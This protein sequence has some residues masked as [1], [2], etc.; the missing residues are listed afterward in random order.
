[1]KKNFLLYLGLLLG[2]PSLFAM[3]LPPKPAK[4]LPEDELIALINQNMSPISSPMKVEKG[5]G[6]NL[7]YSS[8]LR[9]ES[10]LAKAVYKKRLKFFKHY[11]FD[12]INGYT[13]TSNSVTETSGRAANFLRDYLKLN[14]ILKVTYNSIPVLGEELITNFIPEAALNSDP[15]RIPMRQEQLYAIAPLKIPQRANLEPNLQIMQ[16][17]AGNFV[18]S[19]IVMQ[20]KGREYEYTPLR[21]KTQDSTFV[22]APYL[23]QENGKIL[24]GT[25][26]PCYVIKNPDAESIALALTQL[27]LKNAST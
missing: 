22:I 12:H 26:V 27:Q 10:N 3:E 7:N 20:E 5:F 1:M 14:L 16:T 13:K 15:I 24:I 25:K 21:I 4:V 17:P 6:Q 19:P 8:L 11:L 2:S 18:M 9:P 23:K